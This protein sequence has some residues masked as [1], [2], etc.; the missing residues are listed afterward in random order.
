[1]SFVKD[2]IKAGVGYAAFIAITYAGVAAG[3]G[4]FEPVSEFV[5]D[6]TENLLD[7]IKDKAEA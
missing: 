1:M 2:C 6:K 7:K 3:F 5:H 4:L